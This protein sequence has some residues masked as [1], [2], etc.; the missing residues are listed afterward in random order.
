M[1]TNGEK[2]RSL[3]GISASELWCMNGESL[4][5]WLNE[6]FIEGKIHVA[7]VKSLIVMGA[8]MNINTDAERK[9][10]EQSKS[11]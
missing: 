8:N 11:D 5:D 2:F 7:S 1:M 6:D 9:N 3:F 10:D 4:I